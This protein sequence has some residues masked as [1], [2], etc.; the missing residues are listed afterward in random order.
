MK[1]L[2]IWSILCVLVGSCAPKNNG[3]LRIAAAA[4]TQYALTKIAEAFTDSTGQEVDLVFGASG[5]L[6]TQIIEKAPFDLF[7]SANMAYPIELKDRKLATDTPQVYAHGQLVM[8]TTNKEVDL[9][10]DSLHLFKKIAVANPQIAP[11]GLLT[12]QILEEHKLWHKVEGAFVFGESIGQVNQY[13]ETGAVELGFTAKS[14]VMAPEHATKGN[15][16]DV[17]SKKYI[18]KQGVV[19]VKNT[20]ESEAK[21]AFYDI[22]FSPTAREIF[23]NLGYKLP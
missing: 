2:V 14:I 1:Q 15:W 3:K 20:P 5:K 6:T 8:W 18:L 13:I 10:V 22:L 12:L 9:H 11:Y 19:M 7:L 23:I 21:Q 4:N 16:I 17:P